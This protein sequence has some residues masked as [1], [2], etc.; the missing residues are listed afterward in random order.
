M[1]LIKGA[2]FHPEFETLDL[3]VRELPSCFRST[4][5]NANITSSPA[6]P[7]PASKSATVASA[8]KGKVCRYWAK[9]AMLRYLN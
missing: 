1:T 8:S 2:S 3:P 5:L 6:K 4:A 7:N 9:V